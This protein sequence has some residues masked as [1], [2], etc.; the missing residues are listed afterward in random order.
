MSRKSEIT[1]TTF[2]DKVY[3]C[4]L[5]FPSCAYAVV[6]GWTCQNCGKNGVAGRD[7]RIEGHDVY[8]A[9]GGCADC[10]II[11]GVVRAKVFSTL[12]G[13]EEDERVLNGRCRVY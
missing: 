4:T 9:N 7:K 2:D 1:F 8:A 12:F 3:T 13:L 11:T 10:K 5:P 6:D